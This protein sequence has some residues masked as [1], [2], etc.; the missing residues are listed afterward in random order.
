M[1]YSFR[2]N[3]RDAL[4]RT[5]PVIG[6]AVGSLLFVVATLFYPGGT[7]TSI[8]SVG[9][10]WAQNYVSTLFEPVALNG[11]VNPARHIAIPAMLSGC[12]SVATIFGH[13]AIK[14]N[15]RSMQ[16]LIALGGTGSM[17]F[18]FLA[19]TT[20]LHDQLLGIG[21]LMFMG[22]AI[23]TLKLQRWLRQSRLVFFGTAS[24]A[25]LAASGIMFYGN[26]LLEYLAVL[27][28]IAIFACTLWLVLTH[29]S[30]FKMESGA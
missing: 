30:T 16:K 3:H 14:C 15:A 24:I 6:I 25:M 7:R 22:A 18:A 9:Y 8:N 4:K 1:I 5:L 21:L 11:A 10:D 20:P 28:K 29:A 26:L 12:V 19:V 2:V 27:Q 23:A 13:L 17:V